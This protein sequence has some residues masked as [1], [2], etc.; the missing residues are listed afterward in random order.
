[1]SNGVFIEK[2]NLLKQLGIYLSSYLNRSKHIDA[3]C[4]KA[5]RKLSFLRTV[6]KLSIKYV[7]NRCYL[8]TKCEV[9]HLNC[10][11]CIL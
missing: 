7:D 6:R 11:T 1:M 5:N 9:C 4:C 3:V 10:V 2:V 8:K